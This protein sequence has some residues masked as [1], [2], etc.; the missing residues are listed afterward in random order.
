[1]IRVPHSKLV[2]LAAAIALCAVA[3]AGWA[4]TTAVRI[5]A[6]QVA[7]YESLGIVALDD[8]D[9]GS[10]RWLILD[11]TQ[12]DRL[13]AAGVT[14]TVVEDA[15]TVQVMG[16]RF[17]PLAEGEPGLPPELRADP[18]RP[19][20]RLLQVVAPVRD[21]W[22]TE[23]GELGITPLQYYPHNTFLVWSGPAEMDRAAELPFVRWHGLFHPAYKPNSNL[24]GLTGIVQNVDVMF[25]NNGR[26]EQ[27]LEDLQKL[28]GVVLQHYPSQPDRRFFNAIVELDAEAVDAAATI[29]TVLW[30]GYQSPEPILDDEMSDQIIADNHP[31]GVPQTGYLSYLAGLG[32]NG[33]GVIWAPIDTGVDYDHPDLFPSI[34]GGYSFPNACVGYPPGSDCAG[35]GH[36]THVSG[37]IGGTGVGDGGGPYT[38]PGGFRY[39]LGVAPG[40][41]IFAMNSLSASAWPPSGGWQEHSKR[42]VLGNAIG[43]NNSWT[44]GEGTQHGYQASE[45]T[46]DIM[47]RDG[48]FDTTNVAEPFIEVFSAGNSGS[49]GLTAPKEGKNLIVT[50]ASVNYRAGNIDT[51][52]SFSSRGPA[53]DGRWVPTIAAPGEQIASTRNDE[54]GSCG[55]AISGTNGL[56]SFCSGTSM[57]APHASGAIVLATEWWRT[58]NAGADPSPAMAKALLVNSADDMG[59]P[60][61]PNIHEGWGRVNVDT[62]INPSVIRVYRDQDHLFGATG[63][64]LVIPLGV[65]DPS[66]PLKVTLAWSDA[67][68]AV[69]ANPA[70][71][72][73]LDLTV[74]TGGSTYLGNVFSGGWS[75][76]GGSA[77]TINNLENVF[78]ASPGGSAIITID[79]TA[80]V[81]DGVP[82]NGDTTDQDFALVCTNCALEPDFYL[83]AAPSDRSICAPADA[84]Y[85]IEVGS[86]LG[87]SEQVT[88]SAS[89]HP[90]GTTASFSTNPVTPPANP[91]LTIGNT[92]SGTAGS[93]SVL[94]TG[95]AATSTHDITIGLTLATASPTAP[96]LVAPADG[97]LNQSARPTFDWSPAAQGESYHIQVASD[98]AFTNLV[99]DRSGLTDTEYTHTTD[100]TTNTQYWWRVG[101]GNACGAGPWSAVWTFTT[102][103]AP[104]DCGTGTAPA[105]HFFDDFE[106]GAPGWTTGGTGSTW[107]LGA[108]VSGSGPHS[109]SFVFHANNVASVSDQRLISPPVTLPSGP[110]HTAITLQ[111]WNYQEMEDSASGCYDGGVLE[112]ST[113]AGT[114]WTYLPTAVMQTDPYDGPISSS[115]SNPLIGYDAWCGD[116]QD[117]L[118]SVVD[119]GAYAGQTVQFRFRLGTDSSV[120]HP[121]WDV[122]D[123]WVQSCIPSE[124]PLFADD[125]ET[126]TTGAWSLTIP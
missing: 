98:A 68:G 60:D 56:Y 120:S 84:P 51:I 6:S 31:G 81:G 71:V 29:A 48:N 66:Q 109:G 28:G 18:D 5:P 117:W 40:Y 72:N 82:Y 52:A 3:T 33:S 78:V 11:E 123:V 79:A 121:G 15:G 75:T 101:S 116:P 124:S 23:L 35:G 103:A 112:I 65:P 67:P 10:F 1:M 43:G 91:T 122:D 83:V 111:F 114:S 126:G 32:Y 7:S 97:A 99:I 24:D 63:E 36:G 25:Y 41:S 12:L 20:L 62:M 37:I 80:I 53:V 100:L 94:V 113:D 76:T 92:G 73:N 46:H 61:I 125:F 16:F 55:T 34:V 44:T 95:T 118:R 45:R 93:Y 115:F 49:S 58:F 21:E 69:G 38:D 89:G 108:G 17:D 96:A 9:Y 59:T 26:I 22:I 27:T 102:L 14:H 2:A 88:L 87:Y 90:A 77:D 107:A 105:V 19:G 74:A 54:G 110:G 64:Q 57:A 39:G 50:A 30:L 42:A 70:L 4:T 106:S 47:V 86:I 85:S 119:I 8:I 13:A 104:G